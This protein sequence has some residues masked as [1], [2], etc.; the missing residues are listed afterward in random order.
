MEGCLATSSMLSDR[1]VSKT[2]PRKGGPPPA[3]ARQPPG[4]P[5]A[6]PSAPVPPVAPTQE[7][8]LHLA[9]LRVLRDARAA[10]RAT[11]H[12]TPC[13]HEA[14]SRLPTAHGM[15]QATPAPAGAGMLPASDRALTRPRPLRGRARQRSL[16]HPR[17]PGGDGWSGQRA[18]PAG[19][20]AAPVSVGAVSPRPQPRQD[21]ASSDH[22]GT[23][24][25]R[26]CLQ[27]WLCT[28]EASTTAEPEAG[29][30]HV[31]DCT[32]GAGEPAFLP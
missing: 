17:L 25:A 3:G 21:S 28:A 32:G 8:A 18:Q 22:R 9:G 29:T 10:R 1:H 6:A 5:S 16:A 14:P 30:R 26:V 7:A 19:R 20:P 24:S 2:Y 11:R 31:R 15:A 23:T 12:A 13:P 27:A 4:G